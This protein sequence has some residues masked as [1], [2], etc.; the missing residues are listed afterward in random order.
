MRHVGTPAAIADTQSKSLW[1]VAVYAMRL[2]HRIDLIMQPVG[3][4]GLWQ[5]DVTFAQVR[6]APPACPL[7]FVSALVDFN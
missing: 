7:G 3:S 2:N 6:R 4:V 1:Y 5:H